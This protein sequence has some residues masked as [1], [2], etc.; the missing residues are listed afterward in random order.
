MHSFS[1]H[2]GLGAVAIRFLSSLHLTF[3]SCL[4]THARVRVAYDRA[5]ILPMFS[6]SAGLEI[7]PLW[8]ERPSLSQRRK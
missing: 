8:E 6:D 7:D 3:R 5:P 1:N 4:T 2:F